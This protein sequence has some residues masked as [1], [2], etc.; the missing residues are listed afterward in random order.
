MDRQGPDVGRQYRSAIFTHGEKQR[1][2]ALKMIANL[3]RSGRYDRP[4]ATQVVAASPFF[5]AE[6]YHQ[7]YKEKI[8][9]SL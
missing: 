6:P 3:N 8:R 4:I 9:K 5:E 2:D 7:Q 1:A